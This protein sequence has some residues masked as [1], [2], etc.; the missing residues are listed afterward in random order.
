MRNIAGEHRSSGPLLAAGRRVRSWLDAGSSLPP[1]LLAF[2]AM[3]LVVLIVVIAVRL[4]WLHDHASRDGADAVTGECPAAAT[5]PSHA[6][7]HPRPSPSV[8]R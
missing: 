1:A 3:A 2:I 4:V 8:Q 7:A 5:T 6:D